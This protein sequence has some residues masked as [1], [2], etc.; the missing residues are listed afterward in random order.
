MRTRFFIIL[1]MS[2]LV[3]AVPFAWA[4]WPVQRGKGGEHGRPPCWQPGDLHM[5]A[6]QTEKLKS[7]QG[8]YLNEI[9]ALR[10]DLLNKRYELNKLMSNP[11]SKASDI[12]AKQEGVFALETQI[13]EK[14]IDYQLKVREI[15]TPQ[16][17]K[18]WRSQ[19]QFGQRRGSSRGMG[20]RKR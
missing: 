7:I 18:R 16:Q 19:G 3:L 2:L 12:K 1:S 20:M 5:T 13:Q 15:L 8:S 10:N 14:V 11:T 9:T 6:E 17:F 4:Q